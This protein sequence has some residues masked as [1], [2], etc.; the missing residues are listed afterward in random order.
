[1]I[2]T[3]DFKRITNDVNGNPRYVCHFLNLDVHG[4]NS[5]LSV[6]ARYDIAVQLAKALGGKRYHTRSY[7]GGLVFQSYNLRDLCEHINRLTNKEEA[8]A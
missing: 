5:G 6:S 4:W 8:T 3:D 1:M 2:T 7:G